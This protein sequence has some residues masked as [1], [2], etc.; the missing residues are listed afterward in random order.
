M[1]PTARS[2]AHLRAQGA[3]VQVVEHWNHYAKRR[4]DLFG[5]IDIVALDGKPGAL[6]VQTTTQN[7]VSHRVLKLKT[8]CAGAMRWWLSAGNRLVIH[9]WA[10]RGARG[11]RKTWSVVER[12]VTLE[13]LHEQVAAERA[14]AY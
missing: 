5:F 10:L 2:L 6:G 9:G 3:L 13:D 4:V 11:K 8:D 1:S 12:I 14:S 7:N